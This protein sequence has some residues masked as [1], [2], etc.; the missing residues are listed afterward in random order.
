MCGGR[1]VVIPWLRKLDKSTKPGKASVLESLLPDGSDPL[2]V[3]DPI[4][5]SAGYLF[6]L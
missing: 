6:V 2:V 4:S 1:V 5:S 3:I